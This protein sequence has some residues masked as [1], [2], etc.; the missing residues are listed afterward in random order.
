MATHPDYP[1]ASSRNKNGREQWRYRADRNA[2][3]INLP[4]QPG[5]AAFEA[6]YTAAIRNAPKPGAVVAHPNAA[7]SNS[8]GAAWRLLLKSS[9]WQALDAATQINKERYLA[10]FLNRR[11][12]EGSTAT[13]RDAPVADVDFHRV[14]ALIA[15]IKTADGNN[16]AK[17]WLEV[18]NLLLMVALRAN[19]IRALPTYGLTVR[20]AV[21][22]GHKEWPRQVR[23]QFEAFHPVGS[24]ARTCY[25]LGFWLGNRRS[26]V[27]SLRWDQLVEAEVK[28]LDGDAKMVTAFHFRQRKNRNQNGGR[29]MFLPVLPWLAE[30]LAPLSRQTGTVLVT[31]KGQPYSDKALTMRMQVWTRQAGIEPG[32]GLHGLRKALGNRLAELGLSTRQIQEVLGHSNLAAADPYVRKAEKRRLVVDAYD[33]LEKAEAEYRAR[34][35][36]AT[37][38]LV[39]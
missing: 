30:A 7:L 21:S 36:R 26:D 10:R 24:A 12:A 1:G 35:A 15:E 2:R 22:D 4:G 29:E 25:E 16:V 32:Y 14:D 5:D 17:R 37:F 6:A 23:E 3:Q 19:W 13:W 33:A 34:R 18:I 11:I 38:K 31:D 27:A 39:E 8:F 28:S 20:P 9:D